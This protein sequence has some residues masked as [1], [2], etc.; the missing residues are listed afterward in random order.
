MRRTVSVRWLTDREHTTKARFA[1]P[2]DGLLQTLLDHLPAAV[3]TQRKDHRTKVMFAHRL[4]P[5]S[6][7]PRTVLPRRCA[8]IPKCAACI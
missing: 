3:K 6:G 8:R 4:N 7:R 5:R 1:R 2:I